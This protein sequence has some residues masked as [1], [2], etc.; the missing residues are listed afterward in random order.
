MIGYLSW[1]LSWTSPPLVIPLER[2]FTFD[3]FFFQ[4]FISRTRVRV[5][6]R[7]LNA[8]ERTHRANIQPSCVLH[9][10]KDQARIKCSL[11]YT[12]NVSSGFMRCLSYRFFSYKLEYFGNK[13][14]CNVSLSST[15]PLRLQ[16]VTWGSRKNGILAF[17]MRLAVAHV[18]RG[19][20]LFVDS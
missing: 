9:N 6:A 17:N 8:Q 3:L 2:F 11:L 16:Y 15:L 13:C 7:K 20:F 10:K 1:Q 18:E 5:S 12:R 14:E 19:C 4:M